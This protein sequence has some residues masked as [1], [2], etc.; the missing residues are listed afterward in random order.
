MAINRWRIIITYSHDYSIG[1]LRFSRHSLRIGHLMLRMNCAET[2]FGIFHA[3]LHSRGVDFGL[4]DAGD[5]D[6]EQRLYSGEIEFSMRD[7]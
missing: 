6:R 5:H 2:S 4:D 3:T 7:P 1:D